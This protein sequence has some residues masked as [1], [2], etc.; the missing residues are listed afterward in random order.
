[1]RKKSIWIILLCLVLLPFGV[2]AETKTQNLEEILTAK[3]IEHD[4]SG[5]KETDDKVPIYLFY[6]ETCTYCESFI[7]FLNSIVGEYG[8]YF[9]LV[10][11]EVWKNAD[12]SNT[13]EEVSEFLGE[14]ATGVPFIV[15]GD[16]TFIGY[17]PSSDESIKKAITD[18]YNSKDKY[19]V[20]KEM[21]KAE[22]EKKKAN[23]NTSNTSV[24]IWNACITLVAVV[25][26][27]F[28]D[29]Q[30]YQKLNNKL[31]E[32]NNKIEKSSNTEKK[33]KGKK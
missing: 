21:E 10:G 12:N 17:G 1:M 11:Y 24:I 33:T 28:Y 25:G 15:I 7:E 14:K 3:N 31:E 26:V 27:V 9:K 18:L 2:K 5:Y 22:K 29:H 13:M 8:K 32:M 4:L 30:K 20:F 19:D 6:G 16:Q 23:K